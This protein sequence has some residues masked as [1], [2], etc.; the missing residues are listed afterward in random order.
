MVSNAVKNFAWG[1]F[2]ILQ[3]K[4]IPDVHGNIKNL[5]YYVKNIVAIEMFM[6]EKNT[7]VQSLQKGLTACI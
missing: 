2:Y 6:R 4:G 7:I 1:T 3:A 5:R